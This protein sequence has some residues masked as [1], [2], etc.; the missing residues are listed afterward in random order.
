MTIDAARF[1]SKR[2]TVIAK[3]RGNGTKLE[4]LV[5]DHDSINYIALLTLDEADQLSIDL[6]RA[7]AS[8]RPEQPM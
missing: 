5:K 6:G 2:F 7:V 4:V 8:L 3:N 1:D